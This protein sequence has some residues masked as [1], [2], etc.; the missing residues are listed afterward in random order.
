MTV[1]ICKAAPADYAAILLIDGESQVKH[2]ITFI[3]RQSM[4][5]M[6]RTMSLALQQS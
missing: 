6:N 2:A 1:H 5:T 3:E 4:Q